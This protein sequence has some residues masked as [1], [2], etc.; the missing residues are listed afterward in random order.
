MKCGVV[1]ELFYKSEGIRAF[2]FAK[3]NTTNLDFLDFNF[4]SEQLT[5]INHSSKQENSHSNA[6]DGLL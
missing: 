3:N 4:N 1:Y 6:C 5:T 2:F